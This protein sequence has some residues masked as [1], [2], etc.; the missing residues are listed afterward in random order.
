MMDLAKIADLAL[1]MID[2]SIGFEMETF[3]FISLL[4]NHGFP[5]V[6]G[7]LTH[8]DYFKDN[9]QLRKTR[10]KYKK[11]FEYEVGSSYK[12]FY[13]TALKNQLYLNHEI[14]NLARFISIIKYTPVRWKSEHPFILADRFE[15]L[16][17][18]ETAFWGYIR[19][20]T[21]R[22]NDR[23]HFVGKGDYTLKDIQVIN[24]P[25]PL[26]KEENKR[27]LK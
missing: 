11:R 16:P 5:N 2:A 27:T 4:N 9:K 1:I 8:I 7:V 20:C 24:D 10:K 21:Y 14:T 3:E 25:C 18:G 19:G 15:K 6:M 17:N 13:L 26:K 23:L 12:L 22:I